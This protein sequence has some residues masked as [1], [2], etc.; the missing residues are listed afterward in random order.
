MQN[1]YVALCSIESLSGDAKNAVVLPG[2]G[3][4]ARGHALE[5]QTQHVERFSPFDCFFHA[6]EDLHPEFVDRIRKQ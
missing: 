5:L 3:D 6:I 1:E 2:R 4:I